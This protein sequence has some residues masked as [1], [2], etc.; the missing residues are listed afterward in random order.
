MQ[1]IRL[2]KQKRLI[3]HGKGLKQSNFEFFR[4]IELGYNKEDI[5]YY[6]NLCGV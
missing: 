6:D 5:L 4:S 3:K 2:I 1:L